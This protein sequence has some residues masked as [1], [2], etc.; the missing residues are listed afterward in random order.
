MR[1][2]ALILAAAVAAGC[3][4]TSN[5]QTVYSV[6]AV[7]YVNLPFKQGFS[8]ISNPLNT[9]NNTIG[10]VLANAPEGTILYKYTG[11]G[12]TISVMDDLGAW[13]RPSITLNPGEGAFVY[14]LNA[15][16]NTFVGEVM[17]GNLTNSLPAGFSIR[18]SQV[19][20]AGTATSL[21][22]ALPE[23]SLVYKLKTTGAGYDIFVVDDLGWAPEPSF[24]VGQAFWVTVPTATEWKRTFSVNP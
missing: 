1:T 21:G 3:A 9:T 10:S 7:G 23:G 14:S 19:P 15:W 20:Q 11:T 12:F 2:K 8:M 16:T 6:N 17:Q 22:L 13:D 5:A 24:E 18:G 4:I